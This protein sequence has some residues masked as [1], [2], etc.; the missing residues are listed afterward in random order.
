MPEFANVLL[1]CLKSTRIFAVMAGDVRSRSCRMKHPLQEAT[2]RRDTLGV[3][4]PEQMLLGRRIMVVE[5]NLMNRRVAEGILS[6][7]GAEVVLAYNGQDAVDQLR[8]TSVPYDLIL[9]DVQMPVMDGLRATAE[10]RRRPGGERVPIVALTASA[11]DADRAQCLAAGM[12]DFLG[13][14]LEPGLL[15]RCLMRWLGP[16][17]TPAAATT[18]ATPSRPARAG[19]PARAQPARSR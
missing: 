5:D 14:P 15:Q 6:N 12:D 9:M 4:L 13:K 2:Q 19:P 8:V 11:F 7:A 10:I 18:R 3:P 17:S 16:A 1:G